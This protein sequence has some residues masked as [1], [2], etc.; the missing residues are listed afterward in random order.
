M[1]NNKGN[2]IMQPKNMNLIIKYGNSNDQTDLFQIA[3]SECIDMG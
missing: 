3:S 2:F 1:V